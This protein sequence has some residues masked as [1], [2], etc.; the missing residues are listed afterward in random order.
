MGR[1][2]DYVFHPRSIAVAGASSSPDKSGH[3]YLKTLL[4]DGFPGAVYPVNHRA[5]EV[6]GIRAYP[7]VREIPGDVDY[8]ISS[9]PNRGAL[10]LVDACAGDHRPDCPIL[11]DLATKHR[12]EEQLPE[13]ARPW[14]PEGDGRQCSL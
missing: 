11:A 5:E 3:T 12:G 7:S 6:L 10:D 13:P 4:D 14:H 2:L 1:E 8:V 9:I